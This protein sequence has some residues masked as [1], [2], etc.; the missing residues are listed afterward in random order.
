VVNAENT[1]T[2]ISVTVILNRRLVYEKLEWFTK[3]PVSALLGI[4][5]LNPELK[6]TVLRTITLDPKPESGLNTEL[7][8][9]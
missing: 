5:K 6:S 7:I 1:G 8:L 4:S 2:G 9:T 3:E